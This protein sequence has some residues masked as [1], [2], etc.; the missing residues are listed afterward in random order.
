MLCSQEIYQRL[1]AAYGKPRWW[2]DDPF[3]VLLQSILV[4]RTAWSNVEKTWAEWGAQLTPEHVGGMTAGELEA[5]IAPCGCQRAKARAIFG[6]TEW[7]RGYG[8]DRRAVRKVPLPDLRKELLALRGVGAETADVILVYAFERPSFI[9][10]A[11]TRRLLTRLGYGFPD[12]GAAR[13]FLTDGL[14]RDARLYGWYHWL[15]LEHCIAACRKAPVCT[16]CPLRDVCERA[17]P[18]E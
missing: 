16:A 7:F 18:A 11:Y 2:S 4:Q 13:G 9:L 1:L 8:F 10:D 14:P 15:I 12:D 3:T 6:L 5:I 17:E